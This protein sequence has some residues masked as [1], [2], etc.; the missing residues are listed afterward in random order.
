MDTQLSLQEK[1]AVYEF[2]AL[3]HR[4]GATR[5]QAV[6]LVVEE[7]PKVSVTQADGIVA[8]LYPLRDAARERLMSYRRV[9]LVAA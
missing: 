2:V 1:A 3:C 8:Y 7:Q 6:S 4:C 5:E 9:D